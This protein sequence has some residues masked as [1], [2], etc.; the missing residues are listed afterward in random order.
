MTFTACSEGHAPIE[1][2]IHA[3]EAAIDAACRRVLR[4]KQ[5][6]GLLPTEPEV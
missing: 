1:D 2:R 4:W 5:A 6:L 3:A